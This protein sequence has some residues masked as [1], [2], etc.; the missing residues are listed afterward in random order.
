MTRI[1]VMRYATSILLLAK[2]RVIFPRH[3]LTVSI[4]VVVNSMVG[5][6][7]RF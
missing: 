3:V 1:V 2:H 5:R 6:M 4:A 7:G